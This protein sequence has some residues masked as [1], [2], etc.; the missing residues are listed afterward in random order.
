MYSKET[1]EKISGWLNAKPYR[2]NILKFIY[3]VLPIFVFV[4]YPILL[5]YLLL[6]HSP[7]LLRC[8]TVPLGVFVTVTLIRKF[9]D[10]QR[11]YEKLGIT[12]LMAKDTKGLSFPSRH[13]ASAAV[14]AMAF[15]Y[16][17]VP[18]GAAF[19]VVAALIGL[20]RICAGVHFPV[21]VISG[22][23]YSVAMSCLFFY[24]L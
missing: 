7:K 9:I 14:I 10:A 1:F 17:N 3:K 20:S 5:L 18:L 12:P 15:L 16:V 23:L 21:D 2:F 11:P 4:G 22:Y 24:I 6:T 19:L 8:I 13:T